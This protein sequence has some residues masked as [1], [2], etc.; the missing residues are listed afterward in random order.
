MNINDNW[1]FL[2]QSYFYKYHND[3]IMK[4]ILSC[5]ININQMRNIKNNLKI[6]LNIYKYTIAIFIEEKE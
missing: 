2:F 1:A 5:K 6:A 4:K 3:I